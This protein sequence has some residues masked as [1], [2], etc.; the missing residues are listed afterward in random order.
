MQKA[1][2][3]IEIA[4]VVVVGAGA[5]FIGRAIPSVPSGSSSVSAPVSAPTSPTRADGPA[6][7]TVPSAT[8]TNLP[9]GEAAPDVVKP[10]SRTSPISIRNF[11]VT[12]QNNAVSPDTIVL[13]LNDLL[14]LTFQSKDNTYSFVQPDYALRWEVSPTAP[15]SLQLQTDRP[16]KFTFYCPSCG[17]PAKGPVGYIIVVPR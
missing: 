12:V 16:G 6:G 11:N 7:T 10:A 8:S 2:I 4:A 13:Y 14:N 15:K 1:R 3:W 5:F 9:P 17:G